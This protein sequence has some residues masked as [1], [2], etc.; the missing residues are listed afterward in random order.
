MPADPEP[1]VAERIAAVLQELDP[2]QRAVAEALRGPVCVLAGAGTGKTRALTHRIAHGVLTGEY[3]PGQVLP[4]TFSVR[5]AG[6]L[7]ERLRALGVGGVRA[8]TFHSAALAQLRYFWPRHIGGEPP[9]V[10]PSK[11]AQ[12]VT[13]LARRRIGS[14]PSLVRD[15]SGEI[16]W[17]KVSQITPDSYAEQVAALGRVPAPSLAPAEIARV[18]AAYEEV[19]RDRGV[20]DFEDCLLLAVGI[21]DEQPDAARQVRAQYRH[22]V[23]DEYQ[24]VSPLQQRLLDLW[25]GDRD[26]VCVVGDASQTI[27]SFAGATPRFLL[28]FES[29]YP[30]ATV[31]R[32]HRDYRSTPQVVGLANAVLAP[33]SGAAARARVTLVGQRPP[34]PQPV[35]AGHAD[36]AAEAAWVAQ[37]VKAL[38]AQ[39]VPLREIAVLYRLNAQSEVYEEALAEAAVP[40][41]VRG[42]QRF[43]D[44][45]EVRQAVTL[46]RGSARAGEGAGV[47][48][49]EQA[50]EV[51]TVAGWTAQP[52]A[53]SGA[54]RERWESLAALAAL[55][56]AVAAA[57]RRPGCPELVAELDERASAQHA[58]TADGVTLSTI[59]A[60]KGLEWDAVFAVGLID[61][62]LPLV[63]A[64]T[65]EQIEEERRLLY[66]AVTRAREH[67]AVS[68]GRRRSAGGR[69]RAP[70]RFLEPLG[71]GAAESPAGRG[72]AAKGPRAPT[73][74]PRCRGCGAGLTGGAQRKRGRC[75]RCP[76]TYDEA[77]LAGLKAWRLETAKA[78][79]VPAYVVFTDATLE[80]IAELRP[81]TRAELAGIGGVGAA[82]L[83]RYADDVLRLVSGG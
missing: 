61:G 54:A 14:D 59:H 44:R 45:P 5:A 75:D 34:G 1:S 53:G 20:L 76:P 29:R 15:V 82:K 50:R 19:K 36:E 62:T 37:R 70:S 41:V 52:P 31:V 64:T 57:T 24:D 3:A 74:V 83:E 4:V 11:A 68:W 39:G 51:L 30:S 28:D 79:A 66:V 21:L 38:A 65:P 43:F 12:V 13:A 16:E 42:G 32:L 49:P 78:A 33:A 2:E 7:R 47:A 40:Y 48:L 9:R 77:L 80:A 26:D 63:F 72:R 18:Y 17:A 73:V 22:L 58:P 35:L 6:E 69:E 55:A 81:K 23:V 10:E 56:E 8:R 27:Y 67:L 46:L 71:Q 25:L 60:A